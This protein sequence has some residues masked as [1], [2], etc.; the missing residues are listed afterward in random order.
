MQIGVIIGNGTAI[1]ILTNLKPFNL[2]QM[3]NVLPQK[4]NFKN[5]HIHKLQNN[6]NTYT[7]EVTIELISKQEDK[8]TWVILHDKDLLRELKVSKGQFLVKNFLLLFFTNF[9]LEKIKNGHI[10]YL[11]HNFFIQI[12]LL[13]VFYLKQAISLNL[14]KMIFL[15]LM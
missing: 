11:R 12:N 4:D 9:N 5:S 7:L 2:T 6:S 8:N 1:L 13:K 14:N 3:M 10:R 15:K